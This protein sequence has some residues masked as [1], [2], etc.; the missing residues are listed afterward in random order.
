MASLAAAKEVIRK[1]ESEPIFDSVWEQGKR[2][3]DGFNTLVKATETSDI[4]GIQGLAPR[5]LVQF[6]GQNEHHSL[7]LKTFFQ[8]ECAKRGV[9][10]SGSHFIS[11]AHTHDVIDQT[12]RVYATVMRLLKENLS[13]LESLLEGPVLRP[14]FRKP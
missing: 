1:M 6:K 8:Q 2:L 10:F 13:N 4:L 9:F 12:L 7:V 11:Y 3:I 14:V 5:S